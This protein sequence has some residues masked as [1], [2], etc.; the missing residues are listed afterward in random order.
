MELVKLVI[1]SSKLSVAVIFNDAFNYHG[2]N[3]EG[4]FIPLFRVF[5]KY[6]QCPMILEKE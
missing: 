5:E 3:M 1:A 2:S 6:T 4:I